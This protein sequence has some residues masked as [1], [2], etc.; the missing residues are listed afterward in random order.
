VFVTHDVEEALLLSD[1]VLVMSARPGRFVADTAID[2]V[3]P[4][5]PELVADPAFVAQRAA[6]LDALGA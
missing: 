3:R 6:L 4:R 5:S 1:R 2:F